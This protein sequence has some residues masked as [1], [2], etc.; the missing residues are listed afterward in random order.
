MEKRVSFVL[1][2][3]AFGGSERVISCLSNC[4]ASHFGLKVQLIFLWDKIIQYPLDKTIEI[5]VISPKVKALPLPLAVKK[6]TEFILQKTKEF[7]SD[8]VISFLATVNM[9]CLIALKN[10]GIPLLISERNDPRQNPESLFERQLRD[11]MYK[12]WTFKALVVQNSF[13]LNYFQKFLSQKTKITIIEN[14][15]SPNLPMPFKGEKCKIVVAVGRLENQKNYP[16]LLKAFKDTSPIYTLEIYGE[17]SQ[18]KALKQLAKQL[19]IDQRVQFM[20]VHKDLHE[21]I[22][23][24]GA[25][26]MTSFYEGQP[27]ALIEAIALGL[28]CV[29]KDFEGVENLISQ[30]ENGYICKDEKQFS[31]ALNL[32]LKS[33]LAEKNLIEKAESIR[34]NH[35]EKAITNQWLSLLFND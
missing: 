6:R 25:F 1:Y 17:G 23:D 32:V 27:N 11:F 24:C 20:G 33:P 4:M 30:G 19:E 13:S 5:S 3:L 22:K 10:T 8:G 12:H 7:K 16:F 15:L 35:E 2:N 21:K 31:T 29:V 34:E 28:P 9:Y 14:L 26:A 18:E